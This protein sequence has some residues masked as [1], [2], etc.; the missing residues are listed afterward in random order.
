MIFLISNVYRYQLNRSIFFIIYI[1]IIIFSFLFSLKKDR[2][3]GLAFGI[4]MTIIT[5]L[6]DIK[7]TKY[8]V[9]PSITLALTNA[10]IID[11]ENVVSLVTCFTI[12]WYCA[13]ISYVA[14]LSFIC[15]HSLI[16]YIFFPIYIMIIAVTSASRQGAA[17]NI[18]LVS[19]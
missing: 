14:S 19:C 3:A 11:A 17:Q 7:I 2:I 15:T 16:S 5:V 4:I 10:R 18:A 9:K 8:F 1:S 12:V 6:V 13:K